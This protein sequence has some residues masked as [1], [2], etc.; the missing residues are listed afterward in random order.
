MTTSN[1][2]PGK[3]FVTAEAAVLWMVSGKPWFEN[4]IGTGWRDMPCHGVPIIWPESNTRY[5][6]AIP[7]DDDGLIHGTMTDPVTGESRPMTYQADKLEGEKRVT[8]PKCKGTGTGEEPISRY[9]NCSR[10]HGTGKVPV[11]PSPAPPLTSEGEMRTGSAMCANCYVVLPS[12]QALVAH[13]AGSGCKA[14]TGKTVAET[15]PWTER[16]SICKTPLPDNYIFFACKKCRDAG[17]GDGGRRKATEPVGRPIT[18]A[19]ALES[20]SRTL[21]RAERERIDGSGD[22]GGRKATEPPKRLK[23]RCACNWWTAWSGNQLLHQDGTVC[24]EDDCSVEEP[25]RKPSPEPLPALPPLPAMWPVKPD[26]WP[27]NS[28]WVP[29]NGFTV[30]SDDPAFPSTLEANA[31]RAQVKKLYPALVEER[32][33]H[34][35]HRAGVAAAQREIVAALA[36]I[37]Y[38]KDVLTVIRAARDEALALLREP[39]QEG[40]WE[41]KRITLLAQFPQDEPA[42]K[43]ETCSNCGAPL[44][45]WEGPS[46]VGCPM[47]LDLD[48]GRLANGDCIR[49]KK[50]DAK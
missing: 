33:R 4:P 13:Q 34:E 30:D 29:M 38:L 43:P 15:V 42:A 26:G 6:P 1:L 32:E 17:S 12:V 3:P 44:Y 18:R 10:C 9:Y 11:V 20:A 21:E 45:T 47:H 27:S 37:V 8:C 16:C 48:P 25:G 19:A 5:A 50:E 7:A 28:S 23:G 2:K 22:A 36:E 41:R 46:G 35:R 40:A 24:A 39:V 31:L 14:H 49:L